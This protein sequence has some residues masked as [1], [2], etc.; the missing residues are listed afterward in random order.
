MFQEEH[1]PFN[2][3]QKCH[4][5][6]IYIVEEKQKNHITSNPCRTIFQMKE[7]KRFLWLPFEC[8]LARKQNVS[9][10]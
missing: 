10:W 1:I 9:K 6:N 7:N 5:T 4:I 8:F 2:E 3:H